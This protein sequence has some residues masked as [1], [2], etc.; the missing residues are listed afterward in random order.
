[1][2]YLQLVQKTVRKSGA[3]VK[4]PTTV[5]GQEGISFEFVEWVQEAWKKLQLER[6]GVGWR[7]VRDLSFS[8]VVGTTDYTTP[9][10]LESINARSLKISLSGENETNLSY[11]V[12]DDYMVEA[13]RL[14]PMDGKPAYFTINPYNGDMILWP[15]ADEIYT[16]RYEGIRAVQEFDYTDAD[17]VGTSDIL[18]PTG[19]QDIYHDAIV[20][21]AVRNYA[22]SKEDGSKLSEANAQFM[23]YKKYFEERFM[24]VV[25]VDTAA[26]YSPVSRQAIWY[27]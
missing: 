11:R 12:Y 7:V 21:E 16:V 9:A 3:K 8:T 17:G 24:P 4:P 18:T 5:V 6:L 27:V 14:D 13:D 26:L 25:Q 15:V 10:T 1:M 23:P 19:L 20:W 22:M 2:N